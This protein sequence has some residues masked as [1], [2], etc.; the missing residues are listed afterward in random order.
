MNSKALHLGLFVLRFGIGVVFIMYGYPKLS[1]G[2]DRWADMG[3]AVMEPLG[4]EFAYAMWGFLSALAQAI[5]GLFL[6]LG[7]MVRPAAVCLLLTTGLSTAAI[8]AAESGFLRS[9]QF[10][11]FAEPLTLSIVFLALICAGG[12]DYA[13]GKAVKPLDGKWYQ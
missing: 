7:L 5:G 9:L 13:M 6:A 12:G 4:I 8:I 3:E 1:D 11:D 2:P 10:S